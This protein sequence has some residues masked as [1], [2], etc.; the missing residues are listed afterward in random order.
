MRHRQTKGPETGRSDLI[1]RVTP[2]LYPAW[3]LLSEYPFWRNC[4]QVLRTLVVEEAVHS[5]KPKRQAPVVSG[6][7][8]DATDFRDLFSGR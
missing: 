5:C 3:V 2:R 7:P 4:Q 6:I 1:N 8:E